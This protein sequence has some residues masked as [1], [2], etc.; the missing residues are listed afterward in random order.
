MDY[1]ISLVA[2]LSAALS[3]TDNQA[4]LVPLSEPPGAEATE[5]Q[6]PAKRPNPEAANLERLLQRQS[7]PLPLA[8][9]NLAEITVR[10]FDEK[11]ERP[12]GG[13]PLTQ[14][15]FNQMLLA[16]LPSRVPNLT[17]LRSSRPDRLPTKAYPNVGSQALARIRD[18]NDQP[19][20]IATSDEPTAAPI[21][22]NP[23]PLLRRSQSHFSADLVPVYRRDQRLR[24]N[25]GGPKDHSQKGE[26]AAARDQSLNEAAQALAF[27]VGFITAVLG[28]VFLIAT[29]GALCRAIGL[30]LLALAAWML[31]S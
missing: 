12:R 4:N 28:F 14:I 30:G 20:P 24:Q 29:E 19:T 18:R 3:G 27:I 25:I 26:D 8:S 31:L 23:R 9:P 1:V 10:N 7:E 5:A 21:A 6:Q 17:R 2:A 22:D 13:I 16:W 15:H 11:S